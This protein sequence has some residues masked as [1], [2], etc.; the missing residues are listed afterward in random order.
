[1]DTN[2]TRVNHMS[3]HYDSS[4]EILN[5]IYMNYSV[6][7]KSVISRIKEDKNLS[8]FDAFNKRLKITWGMKIEYTD[9]LPITG[10]ATRI[11]Y[12]LMLK[13]S[14]LWFAFE[15]LVA[16]SNTIIP[17]DAAK[18][19]SKVDLYRDSTL[20]ELGF[21]NINENFNQLMK[22]F[23]LN[24]SNRR[25]DMYIVLAYIKNNTERGTQTLLKEVVDLIR[26]GSELQTK[27]IFA[28]SYGIRNIYAHKGVSAA[29][30]SNNYELKRDFYRVLY[31]SL[32]LYS[33]ALGNAF[34]EKY[35]A[36]INS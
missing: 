18:N 26:E 4:K 21:N 13:I 9:E 7:S 20:E 31:D 5:M 2:L 36:S 6:N 1:M 8:K 12:T 19:N 25:R 34:C 10:E 23:I 24:K 14:D 28:L 30:G 11:C 3:L 16:T 27:H 22:S 29:L 15:H 17:K 35:L 33:L 32:I